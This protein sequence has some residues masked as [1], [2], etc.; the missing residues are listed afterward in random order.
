M[1]V[2][3]ALLTLAAAYPTWKALQDPEAAERRM[4]TS[5]RAKLYL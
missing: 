1:F 5:Q 2:I 3:L 4:R